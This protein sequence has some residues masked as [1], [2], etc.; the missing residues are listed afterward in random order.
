MFAI[1]ALALTSSALPAQAASDKA[2]KTRSGAAAASSNMASLRADAGTDVQGATSSAV[3][4]GRPGQLQQGFQEYR[5]GPGDVLGIEV[6][7]EPDASSASVAVRPDGKISLPMVGE[8]HAAGLTPN[9]LEKLLAPK[10]RDLIRVTRLTV[11][12][13]EINS[14]KVYLIGE[15]KKEGPIR[16]QAPITVLQALAEAGGVTDYAKRRK[17]YIL[18]SFANGRQI[19]PF[20]YDAVVRGDK[21]EQNIVVSGGDTIVVPR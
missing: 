11:M 15:V 18:R 2:K 7:K 12:V 10:Y 1:V 19:L 8:M 14:Q 21:M 5:I 13:K 6:W 16:L 4:T 3:N 17:I 9:E 20:D